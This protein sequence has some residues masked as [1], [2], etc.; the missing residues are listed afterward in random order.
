MT[1]QNDIG[2]VCPSATSLSGLG[3]PLAVTT[4]VKFHMHRGCVTCRAAVGKARSLQVVDDPRL[5]QPRLLLAHIL[6]LWWM[7]PQQR[8][9][10][11]CGSSPELS[12]A[13]SL[14]PW[15]RSSH[16]R[17]CL[18]A[19]LLLLPEKEV[20][21]RRTHKCATVVGLDYFVLPLAPHSRSS[22]AVFLLPNP[23]AASCW[24]QGT[25]LAMLH[26]GLAVA[27]LLGPHP[28]IFSLTWSNQP[29]QIWAYPQGIHD[30]RTVPE[31]WEK[32]CYILSLK[33]T[34]TPAPHP[35]GLPYELCCYFIHFP[36][37]T[38][39]EPVACRVSCLGSSSLVC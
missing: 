33:H 39:E 35:F 31:R 1:V 18:P 2:C 21:T 13:G 32:K 3:N 7:P 15:W 36:Q 24:N 19:F 27:L 10:L 11:G 22:E 5:R 14:K 29:L 26:P 25:P 16:R 6:T 9:G 23:S 20:L 37:Q 30:A 34:D 12:N 17:C 4:R 38:E 8:R 28:T